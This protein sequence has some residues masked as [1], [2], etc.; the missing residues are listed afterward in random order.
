MDKSPSEEDLPIGTQFDREM[1]QQCIALARRALGRTAPNPLVGAVVVR[2]GEIV[3]TG[4][5]PQA[6]APHAEVFALKEAG[7]LARGATLYVNLEPCNHH[8]RT[9]PCSEAVV[10]AG[11]AKVVVGIVDPNPLVAGSGIARLQQA[12]I[13]VLVGVEAAA[14]Q[15]LNEAFI[16]R[17]LHQRSFGILKYAM[18]LDGKIATS[19]G[20]SAWITSTD[21]RQEVHQLRAACDAVIVGGNTVRRDNPQ[22]TSHHP[23]ARNPLR[24]VMSRTLD[25]P[26]EAHLWETE[27]APT[28]VLTEPGVDR[29]LQSFLQKKQV[30]V[31]ELAPLTPAQVMAYLYDRQLLSVLW[32]CGGT[33]AARAIAEGAVQKVLAFIAP[34]IVG[35]SAAPSPVGELGL[36]NMNEALVLSSVSWRTIG[37]DCLVEGYLSEVISLP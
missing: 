28:L 20:H 31:V 18:T 24:I 17:I 33:L 13:E 36:E 37:S 12:G 11:V 27:V 21:A 4:F 5:H 3:G 30:E 2:D 6:G 15:Q 19:T 35:G 1:M 9:P 29:S 10:A 26:T 14:C 8:G 25:L 34:K 22:L 16:H 7:E 23:Q 32:E